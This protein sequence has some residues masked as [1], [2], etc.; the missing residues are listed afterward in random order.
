MLL[1]YSPETKSAY[2]LKSGARR[3]EKQDFL[4]VYMEVEYHTFETY[5][6][7]ISDDRQMIA[8][9]SYTGA[10]RLEEQRDNK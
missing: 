1:A 8:N 7:F 5:I 9:S 2:Y 10:I 4:E 3:H 6:S